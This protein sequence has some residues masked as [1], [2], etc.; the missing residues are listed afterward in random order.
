MSDYVLTVPEEVYTRAR[1]IAEETSQL[2][3]E[4]MIQYLRTLSTPLPTLPPDEEAELDALKNLSDDALWTIA[5]EQMTDDLQI[6]MQDL[7]DKNSL[8]TITSKEYIELEGLV[9]RGQRLMVRKSEASALLTQRGY[10]ITPKD[11]RARE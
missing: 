5:R 6:R 2:V 8:G 11:M 9:E 4:V 7:M 1:Q 10:K 3:D